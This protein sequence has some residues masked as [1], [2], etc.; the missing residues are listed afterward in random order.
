MVATIKKKLNISW[1][2]EIIRR[3][4]WNYFGLQT[5][6]IIWFYGL[7]RCS[8]KDDVIIVPVMRKSNSQSI[9]PI[10]TK[11]TSEQRLSHRKFLRLLYRAVFSFYDAHVKIYQLYRYSWSFRYPFY[12]SEKLKK[13]IYSNK[14]ASVSIRFKRNKIYAKNSSAAFS[15]FFFRTFTINVRRKIQRIYASFFPRKNKKIV[16]KFAFYFDVLDVI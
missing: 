2:C 10:L 7:S 9:L 13:K 5:L 1:F 6:I 8:A 12:S 14:Y 11:Y 15:L 4:Q 16:V 3:T